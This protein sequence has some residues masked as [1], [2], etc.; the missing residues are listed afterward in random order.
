PWNTCGAY[1]SATL[2]VATFSYAPYAFF[3]LLCP[4]IAI[5][6]AFLSIAIKPADSE[7]AVPARSS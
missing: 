2:G 6:Y 3:N 5:A 4:I 7:A 1:M